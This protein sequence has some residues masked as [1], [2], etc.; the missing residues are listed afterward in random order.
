LKARNVFKGGLTASKMKCIAKFNYHSK[1][2]NAIN[3]G[4]NCDRCLRC[5][6][7]ED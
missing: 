6:L 5:T 3:K 1:Q 2:N 7:Q 4:N